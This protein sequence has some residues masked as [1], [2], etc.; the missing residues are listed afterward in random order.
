MTV[1]IAHDFICPW[2]WVGLIQAERL[3]L[4]FGIELNWIGYELWPAN[5]ERGTYGE[6]PPPIPNKPKTPTR[7]EFLLYADGLELPK[8]NRP[9]NMATHNAH[10]AIEYAKTEGTQDAMNAA[11]YTAYWE[12]GENINEPEV[13]ARLADGIVKNLDALK[14][15][16]ATQQFAANI[17]GFD[18]PAYASGVF[19]VPTFF[20][21]GERYAEQPYV[22]LRDAVKAAQRAVA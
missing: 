18:D 6:I 2:C 11:L 1:A 7:F 14:H 10:E 12:R 17:I 19:N 3:K 16:V 13:I 22:V 9:Q 5:L 4:E 15:A 20:I 8:S 21:N